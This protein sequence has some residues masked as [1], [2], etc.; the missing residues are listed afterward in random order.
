MK[1][2]VTVCTI[3]LYPMSNAHNIGLCWL[4]CSDICFMKMYNPLQLVENN[5]KICVMTS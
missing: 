4:Q 1:S 5:I 2:S 3:C